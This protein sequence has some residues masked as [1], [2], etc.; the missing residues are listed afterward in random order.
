MS[1]NYII[2]LSILIT[3]IF[4]TT[5][6][7]FSIIFKALVNKLKVVLC[8]VII[9]G[10]SEFEFLIFFNEFGGLFQLKYFLYLR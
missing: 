2:V 9:I 1:T 7:K 4:D 8:V 6:S 10:T 5:K 3:V